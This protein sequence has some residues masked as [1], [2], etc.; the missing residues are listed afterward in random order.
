MREI[1]RALAQLEDE[2]ETAVGT[3]LNEAMMLCAL[4]GE[5]VP[6]TEVASRMGLR[7]AHTSKIL[8][9]LEERALVTRRLGETDRR[10]IYYA[11]SSEG[12]A[13]LARLRSLELNVPERLRPLFDC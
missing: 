5:E 9:V 3:S 7:N 4:S 2:L 6:S 13:L 1:V 12:E 10:R 11:L 8:A